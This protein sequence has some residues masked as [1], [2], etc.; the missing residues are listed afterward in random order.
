MQSKLKSPRYSIK[1]T[2][3]FR[4]I[5]NTPCLVLLTDLHPISHSISFVQ[6][7]SANSC[8][9]SSSWKLLKLKKFPTLCIVRHQTQSSSY[10][11]HDIQ[12]GSQ[13]SLWIAMLW[14][15]SC[16]KCNRRRKYGLFS[17]FSVPKSFLFS[18]GTPFFPE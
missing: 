8:C 5:K 3:I 12:S 17:Y 6:F 2:R 11:S 10:N 16:E 13:D 7:C 18:S 14:S 15:F 4:K 1:P 9:R